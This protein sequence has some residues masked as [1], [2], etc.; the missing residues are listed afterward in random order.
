MR[1]QKDEN[2]VVSKELIDR[3]RLAL[4]RWMYDVGIP[5]NAVNYD[6]FQEAIEA[7]GQFGPG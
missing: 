3:A 1:Q 5:F 2:F 4:A 6:S 7:V